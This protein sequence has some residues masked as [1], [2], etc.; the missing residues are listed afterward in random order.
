MKA[1]CGL[2]ILDAEIFLAKI[3]N[4]LMAMSLRRKKKGNEAT[5]LFDVLNFMRGFG[6]SFPS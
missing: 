3:G 1:D 6:V 4:W 5:L 2:Q